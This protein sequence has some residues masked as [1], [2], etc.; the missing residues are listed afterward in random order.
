MRS[1]RALTVWFT[2]GP[3][4]LLIVGLLAL[5]SVGIALNGLHATDEFRL[6]DGARES[7]S[8][9]SRLGVY[10]DSASRFR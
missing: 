2:L 3:W 5:N 9:L 10:R 7:A 8:Q 4:A 6:I 1:P